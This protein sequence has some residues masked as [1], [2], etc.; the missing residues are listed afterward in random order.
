MKHFL[1]TCKN[2]YKSQT[3]EMWKTTLT[4]LRFI[5]AYTGERMVVI[6][7]R[8]V[9]AELDKQQAEASIVNQ[10]LGLEA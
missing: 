6:L 4:D 10:F 2:T 3:V 8:L 9:K 1:V 7:D 5:H